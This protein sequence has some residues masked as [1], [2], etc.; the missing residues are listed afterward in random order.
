MTD[1]AK[2]ERADRGVLM[3][4]QRL[5]EPWEIE[6]TR[7]GLDSE[8]EARV[9]WPHPTIYCIRG[10]GS[11]VEEARLDLVLRLATEVARDEDPYLTSEESRQGLAEAAAA[12]LH[13]LTDYK[14]NE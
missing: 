6:F 2:H 8:I 9:N 5:T 7:R 13:G 4:G 10:K 3:P 1:L 14:E 12:A 11:T